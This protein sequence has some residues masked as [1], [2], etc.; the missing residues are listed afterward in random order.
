M[1]LASLRFQRRISPQTKRLPGVG[2][3]TK[4]FRPDTGLEAGSQF[5]IIPTYAS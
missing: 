4:A 2:L 1:Q 3:I 5:A